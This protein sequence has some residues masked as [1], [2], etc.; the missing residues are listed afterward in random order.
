M[1]L[2]QVDHIDL[3]AIPLLRFSYDQVPEVVKEL[4]PWFLFAENQEN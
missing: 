2:F 3:I 1:E 4:D